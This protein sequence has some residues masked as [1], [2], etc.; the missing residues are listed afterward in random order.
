MANVLIT[1]GS[2]GIGRATALLC[3]KSGWS[4]AV[5]YVRDER[6]ANDTAEA[7]RATG[8]RAITIMGDVASEADVVAMFDVAQR[9]LGVLDGVVINAGIVRPLLP[10]AEMTLDRLQRTFAVNGC[11]P[12]RS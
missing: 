5:N 1:G 9:E 11:L 12:L 4:V 7:V 10:L 6:A 2:R 8:S 3:A